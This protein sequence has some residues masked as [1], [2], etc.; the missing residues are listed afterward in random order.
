MKVTGLR[1]VDIDASDRGHWLFVVVDTDAGITGLGEARQSGN[2]RLVQA[3]L[4][5]MGEQIEGQDPTQPEVVWDRLVGGGGSVFEMLE[6][7]APEDAPAW[8]K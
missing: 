7:P 3:A 6:G 8:R 5:Q 4:L 2:D 1:I